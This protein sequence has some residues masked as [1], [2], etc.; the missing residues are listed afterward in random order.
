MMKDPA[1]LILTC[2]SLVAY[3]KTCYGA[4]RSKVV[5]ISWSEDLPE[6]KF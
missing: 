4:P 6:K 1:A 2:E 3:L 5:L